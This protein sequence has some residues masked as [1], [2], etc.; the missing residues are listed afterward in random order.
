MITT[1]IKNAQSDEIDRIL[2]KLKKLRL[3][4]SDDG[5]KEKLVRCKQKIIRW[6]ILA[7]LS[8]I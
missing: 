3:R 1:P 8:H 7:K 2:D 6:N 4:Q 5:G